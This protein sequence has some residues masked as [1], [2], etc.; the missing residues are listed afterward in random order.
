MIGDVLLQV[1][2]LSVAAKPVR[3]SCFMFSGLHMHMYT[4]MKSILK[5][6]Y[7]LPAHTQ[8]DDIRRL[9]AGPEGTV[10]ELLLSR[11]KDGV[12]YLLSVPLKRARESCSIGYIQPRSPVVTFCLLQDLRSCVEHARSREWNMPESINVQ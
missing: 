1:D 7:M 4:H 12:Q 2:S 11:V 5:Y 6:F 8:V 3:I 10:V 9:I